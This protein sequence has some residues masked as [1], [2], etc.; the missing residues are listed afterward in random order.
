MLTLLASSNP[1]LNVT[2]NLY[3]LTA[4]ETIDVCILLLLI[5]SKWIV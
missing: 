3:H 2:L 5:Y 1:V 4:T